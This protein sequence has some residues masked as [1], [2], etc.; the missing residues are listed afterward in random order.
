MCMYI[1]IYIHIN[2]SKHNIICYNIKINIGPISTGTQGSCSEAFEPERLGTMGMV[3]SRASALGMIIC[4]Y[5][6]IYRE[7]ENV[8]CIYIYIYRDVYTH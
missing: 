8:L 1:Y 5:I 3:S 6:Y 4:V 2:N 7:R